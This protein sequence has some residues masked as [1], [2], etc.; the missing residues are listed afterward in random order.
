MKFRVKTK[1]IAD[2]IERLSMIP[3]KTTIYAHSYIRLLS[4]DNE[5][6]IQA[7][8]GAIFGEVRIA[9]DGEDADLLIDKRVIALI[10]IIKS[11]EIEIDVTPKTGAIKITSDTGVYEF[12]FDVKSCKVFDDYTKQRVSPKLLF[13]SQSEPLLYASYAASIASYNNDAPNSVLNNVQFIVGADN[14]LTINGATNYIITQGVVDG[15]TAN[16]HTFLVSNVIIKPMLKALANV[17]DISISAEA[18]SGIIYFTADNV[19]LY[20]AATQERYANIDR[21]TSKANKESH[22]KAEVSLKAIKSAALRLGDEKHFRLHIDAADNKG[23]ITRD[24]NTTD[25]AAKCDVDIDILISIGILEKMVKIA[26]NIDA[27]YIK[28]ST[29]LYFAEYSNLTIYASPVQPR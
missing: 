19:T 10:G 4:H 2:A 17:G 22:H 29:S 24:T 14:K 18:G 20:V 28:D 13:T 3:Q 8:N 15:N 23:V 21:V 7:F 16:E 11:A 1:E 9:S 6:R 27:L 25:I 12:V 26:P 5:L